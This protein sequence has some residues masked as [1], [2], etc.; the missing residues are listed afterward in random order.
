MSGLPAFTVSRTSLRKLE[1]RAELYRHFF[2]EWP[3]LA[4]SFEREAER[5]AAALKDKPK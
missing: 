3:A 1:R 4:Q 5:I 2:P